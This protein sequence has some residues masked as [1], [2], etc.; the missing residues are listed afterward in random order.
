MTEPSLPVPS[1]SATH[2][3][4]ANSEQGVLLD[5]HKAELQN[6]LQWQTTL[7]QS[8]NL[9][10]RLFHD[11]SATIPS[12]AVP[13]ISPHSVLSREDPPFVQALCEVISPPP[14]PFSTDLGKSCGSQMQCILAFECS[15]RSFWEDANKISYMI[16][17]FRDKVLHWAQA[18]F[19]LDSLAH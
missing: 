18:L 16:T 4:S 6:M 2:L 1:D 19:D 7:L 3:Q 13:S 5:W 10:T 12:A 15:P 14:K 9:L 8:M 17:L 11:F